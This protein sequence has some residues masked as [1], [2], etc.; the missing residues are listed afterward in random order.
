MIDGEVALGVDVD[1]ELLAQQVDAGF[2]DLLA[3]QH[4]RT[5]A[6]HPT[7]AVNTTGRRRVADYCKE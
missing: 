4:F 1:V 2:G 3:D 6:H 7:V 5:F